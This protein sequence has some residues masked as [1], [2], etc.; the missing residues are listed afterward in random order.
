MPIGKR[1]N[2]VVAALRGGVWEGGSSGEGG[3]LGGTIKFQLGRCPM[4]QSRGKKILEL[5][6]KSQDVK[7]YLCSLHPFTLAHTLWHVR[8]EKVSESLTTSQTET[9][10]E[11]EFGMGKD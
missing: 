7:I 11:R 8:T 3:D 1:S 10:K 9:E 2:W 4:A 5:A 6:E